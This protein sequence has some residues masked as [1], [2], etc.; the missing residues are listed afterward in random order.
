[1]V[2]S[3]SFWKGKP[4][5]LLPSANMSV[6]LLWYIGNRFRG[7]GVFSHKPARPTQS[8]CSEVCVWDMHAT[9]NPSRTGFSFAV[10]ASAY[11]RLVIFATSALVFPTDSKNCHIDLHHLCSALCNW[12]YLVSCVFQWLCWHSKSRFRVLSIVMPVICV[13]AACRSCLTCWDAVKKQ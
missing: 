2:Q 7:L 10:C 9:I 8:F 6:F 11:M 1:M 5:L 12:W 4:V 3:I 13:W